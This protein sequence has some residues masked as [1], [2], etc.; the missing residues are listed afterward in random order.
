MV[1]FGIVSLLFFPSFLSHSDFS[2]YVTY[3]CNGQLWYSVSKVL[4]EMA[5]WKLA[6]ELGLDV[7]VIN[8]ATVLGPMLQPTLNASLLLFVNLLKGDPDTQGDNW[9]GVVSV[10]DVAEAHILL[11]ETSHAKGRHLCTEGIYR[12]SD[13]AEELA[14]MYPQYNVYRFKEET[15]PWLVR[16]ADTSKKLKSLGFTFTPRDEVIKATVSDL[17]DKGLLP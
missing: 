4:A 3:A 9:L 11:Y 12:F 1:L 2:L 16:C 15:Q 10:K 5:A 17:Q 13:L 7:V 6:E 14:Q 8:P